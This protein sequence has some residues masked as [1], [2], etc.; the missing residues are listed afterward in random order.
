LPK[1]RGAH[2]GSVYISPHRA[3]TACVAN[4]AEA[5]EPALAE[6]MRSR[7]RRRALFEGSLEL[8]S[9]RTK[10]HSQA[11]VR[12]SAVELERLSRQ[13]LPATPHQSIQQ[14]RQAVDVGVILHRI[15]DIIEQRA[16]FGVEFAQLLFQISRH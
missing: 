13:A 1:E 14:I 2:R 12:R 4:C 6:Q 16:G 7:E 15:G 11:D 5:R 10:L 9:Q 8:R 3:G